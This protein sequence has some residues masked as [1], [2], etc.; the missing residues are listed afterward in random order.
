MTHELEIIYSYLLQKMLQVLTVC[1]S[2]RQELLD[3]ETEVGDVSA[4]ELLVLFDAPKNVD[5]ACAYLPSF[6]SIVDFFMATTVP[7]IVVSQITRSTKNSL[8]LFNAI[9]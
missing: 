8:V 6:P 5:E 7:S 3:I 9:V 4:E 2:L 1:P